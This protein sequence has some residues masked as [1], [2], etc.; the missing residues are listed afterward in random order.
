MQRLDRF[1]R[2]VAVL[3]G[4]VIVGGGVV[5]TLRDSAPTASGSVIRLAFCGLISVPFF[6]RAAGM[7]MDAVAWAGAA[8]LF[9]WF[10]AD[11]KTAT[12]R[13]TMVTSTALA[14]L[15]G[16]LQLRLERNERARAA[17]DAATPRS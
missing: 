1:L 15:G 9:L 3:V 12:G 5:A 14:C 17:A 7:K 13:V 2:L 6:R 11:S 4:M 10:A 16:A 8:I